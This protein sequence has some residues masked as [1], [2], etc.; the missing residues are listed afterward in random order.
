MLSVMYPAVLAGANTSVSGSL[1]VPLLVQSDLTAL[2][3]IFTLL[4]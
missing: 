3:S 1:V 2:F 4:L